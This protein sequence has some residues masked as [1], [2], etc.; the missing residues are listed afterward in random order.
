MDSTGDRT[1]N[2]ST[3]PYNVADAQNQTILHKDFSSLLILI[4]YVIKKGVRSK[5]SM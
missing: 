1:A 4:H 5:G 2:A 3:Q